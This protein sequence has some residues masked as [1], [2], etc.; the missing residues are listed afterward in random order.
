MSRAAGDLQHLPCLLRMGSRTLAV[1]IVDFRLLAA[2]LH[3]WLC[4]WYERRHCWHSLTRIKHKHRLCSR[5]LSAAQLQFAR[6]RPAVHIPIR[7]QEQAA[8]QHAPIT[9]QLL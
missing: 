3:D 1:H 5:L 2:C 4:K 9:H 8:Q 6:C 7:G